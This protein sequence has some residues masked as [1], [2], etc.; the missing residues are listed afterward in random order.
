MMFSLGWCLLKEAV[1]QPQLF[2]RMLSVSVDEGATD[3]DV[4]N[5]DCV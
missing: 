5:N 3:L 4:K 1:K 2:L